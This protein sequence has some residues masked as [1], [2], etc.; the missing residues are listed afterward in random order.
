MPSAQAHT[1]AIVFTN[2]TENHHDRHLDDSHQDLHHENDT[3]E[4]RNTEHHHHCISIGIS[5]AII[6][7]EFKYQ[8]IKPFQPKEKILFY[9]NLNASNF[10][11]ELFQ[12]P[13]A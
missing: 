11:D 9:K 2:D 6:T 7:S 12:P 8:F 13:K 10:L 3:E 4:E 1:D 5:S